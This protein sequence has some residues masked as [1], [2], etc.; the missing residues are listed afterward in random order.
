MAMYIRPLS[1]KEANAFVATL[2]RHNKPTSG[3]KYSL[4]CYKNGV[5]VGVAIV[6]R[7]LARMLDDGQTLE[8]LR[9]CTDGTKNANS[10]LYGACVRVAKEMGYRTIYTYTLK[11][12]SGSSL[13]AAGWAEDGEAGGGSWS[14]P[15]RPRT[16][17]TVDLFG[18]SKKYPTEK[19][20]RWKQELRKDGRYDTE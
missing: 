14:V 17:E 18:V 20:I 1:L 4:G 6:G 7:P 19:K 15:S 3:H 12:E 16:L 13:R 8:V 9:V 10:K 11:S 2:H 5:L